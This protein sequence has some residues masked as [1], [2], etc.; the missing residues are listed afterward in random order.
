MH[1][2][3]I[4]KTEKARLALRI[5][6]WFVSAEQAHSHWSN[7]RKNASQTINN[8]FFFRSFQ[9][10]Q[11]RRITL[12]LF[13]NNKTSSECEFRIKS[14][15]LTRTQDGKEQYPIFINLACSPGFP[16]MAYCRGML[17]DLDFA[18]GKERWICVVNVYTFRS[19]IPSD[20]EMTLR[21]DF[22]PIEAIIPDPIKSINKF[23]EKLIT[24]PRDLGYAITKG[25]SSFPA[26]F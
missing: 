25:Q 7:S 20:Q 17:V 11:L 15:I 4:W 3:P 23:L 16:C 21:F 2:R 26:P 10:R 18:P 12:S 8:F 6:S 9:K 1:T 22:K 14:N 13:T 24:W 5:E 19:A